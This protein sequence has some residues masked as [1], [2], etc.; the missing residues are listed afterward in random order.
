M[1]GGMHRVGKLL[2]VICCFFGSSK[3]LRRVKKP[4]GTRRGRDHINIRP[5]RIN[6]SPHLQP[7]TLEPR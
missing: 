6:L 7:T 4:S 2:L 5:R 3:C 1:L